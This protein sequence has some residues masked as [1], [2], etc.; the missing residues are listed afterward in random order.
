MLLKLLGEVH[1]GGLTVRIGHE[2]PYQELSS[3]SVVATGYGPGDETIASLGIVGPTR[4]DYPG[5][6][7][8]CVPSPATSPAS[9]TRHETCD[10]PPADPEDQRSATTPT[11]CS[12]SRATPTTRRSRRPTGGRPALHPDVNPDPATQ[13]R[14]KEVTRAYE[15]LATPE[16]R[17]L[18]PRRRRLR[19]DGWLR[20]GSRFSFT[21]IM[22]AFF[23]GQPAG[24]PGPGSAAAGASW[25]G[26]ADPDGVELAEAAFGGGG[27][28][29][30]RPCVCTTC[31]GEGAAAG[32]RPVPA[33]PAGVRARWP[34]SSAPSSAGSAPCAPAP[35]AVASAP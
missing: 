9:S 20:P 32:R 7:R 35:P 6:W 27:G 4:M 33:R 11:R 19:R 1:A 30:G 18:R 2:G 17:R 25:S 15:I 10:E 28:R 21:D 26:R 3:T 23:G 8:R 22:D 5:P 13:E 16:A 31:G 24:G 29:G 12:V 14:F 34:T